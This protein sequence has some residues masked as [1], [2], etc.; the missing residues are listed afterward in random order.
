MKDPAR[1]SNV[2]RKPGK[3]RRAFSPLAWKP[4][5]NV[6]VSTKEIPLHKFHSTFST[7]CLWVV[8]G[9]LL[10]SPMIPR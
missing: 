8:I 1:V 2:S 7:S 5:L 4:A 3:T 10:V 9:V 6:P